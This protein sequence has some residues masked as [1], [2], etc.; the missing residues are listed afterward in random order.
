M[1]LSLSKSA[2]LILLFSEGAL[3]RPDVL[4]RPYGVL[5]QTACFSKSFP[6]I[7][8]REPFYFG[9]SIH[10]LR[11]PKL[12]VE[13]PRRAWGQRKQQRSGERPERLPPGDPPSDSLPR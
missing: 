12:K 5:V 10:S 4:E 9:E 13:T 2:F 1:G 6:N 11:E 3:E 8:T 7:S